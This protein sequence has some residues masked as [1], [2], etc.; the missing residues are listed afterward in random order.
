MKKLFFSQIIHKLRETIHIE[1]CMK[2]KVCYTYIFRD[3]ITPIA[4]ESRKID[5]YSIT[6]AIFQ[7]CLEVAAYSVLFG[8]SLTNSLPTLL[9]F[10]YQT[11]G[12]RGHSHIYN[13]LRY[14]QCW[15]GGS[16]SCRSRTLVYSGLSG[17]WQSIPFLLSTSL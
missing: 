11:H 3:W 4:W 9:S 17:L 10:Y 8:C 14:V 16:T 6:F 5:K 1:K 15:Q 12:I 2:I 7:R 13:Q